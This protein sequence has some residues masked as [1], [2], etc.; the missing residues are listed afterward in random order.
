ME[1]HIGDFM[2]IVRCTNYFRT[3]K[4]ADSGITGIQCTYLLCINRTPGISQ[5]QL[6]SQ[7]YKDKSVI[8]RHLASLESNGYIHRESDPKDRRVQKLYLTA[9]A[10]ELLPRIREVFQEWNQILYDGFSYEEILLLSSM[11]RR[12]YSNAELA[13]GHPEHLTERCPASEQAAPAASRKET[14]T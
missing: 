3:Q 7:L 6:A 13:L 10:K 8:T 9:K 14:G 11:L 12:L 4:M 2:R 5:E 1:K